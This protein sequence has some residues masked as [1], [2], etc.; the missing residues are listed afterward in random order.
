MK[1]LYFLLFVACMVA[2]FAL[3]RVPFAWMGFACIACVFAGYFI[4]EDKSRNI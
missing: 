4:E 2:A 3:R 1:A